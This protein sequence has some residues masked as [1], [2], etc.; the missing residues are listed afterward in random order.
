MTFR[1]NLTDPDSR[2]YWD[3]IREKAK[4]YDAMPDWQR[5]VLGR[6]LDRRSDDDAD[7]APGSE[8][9]APIGG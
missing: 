5:G 2:A 6:F 9:E 4:E 8:Q 3:M 1:P 7:A